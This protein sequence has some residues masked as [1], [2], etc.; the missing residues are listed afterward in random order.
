MKTTIHFLA[1]CIVFST[2]SM[3]WAQG[4]PPWM[5]P[6]PAP[7]IL[8]EIA[9]PITEVRADDESEIKLRKFGLGVEVRQNIVPEFFLNLFMRA[10]HEVA[11]PA[12]SAK[13]I[14]RTKTTDVII[15]GSYW[16]IKAPN[17]NWMG[18]G[19][20]W[21]DMEY[22][23]FQNF[24]FVWGQINV[25]WNQPLITGLYFIYG[26]GIGAGAV[27]G[28]I[29]TTPAYNCTA[30]NWRDATT[31]PISG[32]WHSPLDPEREKEDIPRV[33]A[34]LEATFGLRY[35]LFSNVSFKLE[36]GLFLPGFWQVSGSV[37][38]LF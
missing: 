32:C 24:K 17:G 14:Y 19:H 25:V 35:D 8:S 12:Y 38:I 30:D 21:E 28:D 2:A 13:F 6:P 10:A 36:T 29:W 11:T 9:S 7:V 33:M 16:D 4:A 15:K 23:E 22:T 20:D 3:T 31:N 34:A 37:E 18:I 1:F 26:G 5:P 27:M